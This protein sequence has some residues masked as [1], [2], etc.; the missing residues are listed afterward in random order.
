M[1]DVQADKPPIDAVLC[2][3]TYPPGAHGVARALALKAEFGPVL[4]ANRVHARHVGGTETLITREASGVHRYHAHHHPKA[5]EERYTWTDRGDGVCYGVL[6]DE[7]K[8]G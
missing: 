5:G 1:S 2:P 6:T 8:D 7:A 3:Q 4:G